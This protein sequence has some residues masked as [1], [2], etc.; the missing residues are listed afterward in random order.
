[1]DRDTM[2]GEMRA[3]V[4]QLA[5]WAKLYYGSDAQSVPDSEYDEAFDRLARL[6][7]ELGESLPGS[8]THQVGAAASSGFAPHTHRARLWS[9]DKTTTTDG[10]REWAARC[11][12]QRLL[13]G[14]PPLSYV[15]EYK[16]DGLTL[17]LTYQGGA[18]TQAATRGDGVTGEAI[19]AQARAIRGVPQRIAYQGFLEVQGEALM[20]RSVLAA[21]NEA[22]SVPLKNPRNGAAGALRNLDP[23]V[24]ASRNLDVFCYSVGYADNPPYTSHE[25]MI[26][27]LAQNGFPTS[28]FLSS[29]PDIEA[30]LTCFGQIEAQ[31]DEL[32]FDIDGAVVKVA[33]LHTRAALGT[34]DRFP[35]GALAFKFPP[36]EV[37]TTLLS[38]SWQVGRTG[39]LTPLGHLEPVDIAGAT[40]RKATLNNIGDIAR[41]DVA[42]GS[43]VWVRRAGDVIP[44]IIGCV[45]GD[46]AL[47]NP[48]ALPSTCPA[49]GS[50]V[51][52]RG[53]HLFCDN[54]DCPPKRLA[55]LVFFCSREAMDIEGLSEKTLELLIRERGL[56]D[57]SG[58]YQLDEAD[59]QGL[60]GIADKKAKLILR[61]IDASRSRPLARLVHALGIPG[62]GRATARDLAARFGSLPALADAREEALLCVSDV[63][64]VVAASIAGWFADAQNQ[65]LL[66]RLAEGGVRPPEQAAGGGPLAGKTLVLTGTLPTLSRLEAQAM[67]EAAGGKAATSVSKKTD[68]V[69]AGADAGSKLDKASALGV[70]VISEDELRAMAGR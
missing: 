11:E 43:R 20:R 13:E 57:P 46:E 33:D 24:T 42:V 21:Y 60:P 67:I 54:P 29:C 23:A 39:K 41:K 68:F 19:L 47:R 44:E 27:F 66:A 52:M 31:R 45:E 65:A 70:P 30:A 49:C 5:G 18:L 7:A 22:A 56:R 55:A 38:V 17:N 69:V 32:D 28:P 14:L 58:L 59:L 10:V 34:T 62:V 9:L 53:A 61:G 40:V 16:F 15:V 48:I 50:P 63:G 12:R 51:S 25:G 35:R 6:E 26:A 4:D 2:R 36:Q 37:V 8:P 1:M 3:L 64:G